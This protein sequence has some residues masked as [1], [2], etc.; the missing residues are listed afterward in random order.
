[1]MENTIY[2][3][4]TFIGRLGIAATPSGIHHIYFH[5]GDPELPLKETSL[6]KKA[7]IQLSEYFEGKRRVFDIPLIL[8]GSEFQKSV[9]EQLK[10]V[11]YGECI[12]YQDVAYAINNPKACRAVG[13]ANNKNPIPIII[14]CHRIIGKNGT[15]VGYGGGLEIKEKLIYLEK[16]C[17]HH[18]E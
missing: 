8:K 2:Y 1:M 7:H 3:Y 5:K 12:S 17:L 16:S 10:K 6:I 14:P 9:W 11:P 13:M 15:L 18:P 4:D